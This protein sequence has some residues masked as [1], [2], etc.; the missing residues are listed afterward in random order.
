MELKKFVRGSFVLF[1]SPL[2]LVACGG[3]ETKTGAAEQ[4]SLET[5]E[6]KVSYIVGQNMAS[7]FKQDEFAVDKSAFLM[8]IED[9][10]SDRDPRFSEAEIRTIMTEF[11][12]QSQAKRLAALDKIKAENKA[13]GE[14]YLAANAQKE[15]VSVTESGLQ[16]KVLQSGDGASPTAEDRVT[17][18][19]HGTLI[20]GTVFDS[21]VDRGQPATF[22]V[23]GVI[24]GW[25][26]ALQ[27]MKVGDKFELTIPS[28]LAYG[29][30]AR[31]GKIQPNS[32]LVFEV[33]LLDIAN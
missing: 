8:G 23:S 5:L 12:E 10:E 4:I 24:K 16:Y 11:Q 25:T 31:S 7:Q 13:K 29:E 32:V 18:H 9:A 6:Q 1:A 22:S 30:Q 2:I 26:E 33:E 28:E 20:D 14:A 3:D 15:G 17:V 27:L 19:Y 21:S